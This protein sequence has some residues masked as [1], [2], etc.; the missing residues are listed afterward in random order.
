MFT[1]AYLH[2]KGPPHVGSDGKSGNEEPTEQILEPQ[3]H[4]QPLHSAIFLSSLKVPP[5]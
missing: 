5:D 3:L 4:V 1:L 2:N